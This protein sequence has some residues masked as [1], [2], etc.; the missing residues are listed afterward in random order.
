MVGGAA[1][2]VEV[3]R[4]AGI[5][6]VIVAGRYIALMNKKS[7]I[8]CWVTGDFNF[9]FKL[10]EKRCE[11][12]EGVGKLTLK[13]DKQADLGRMTFDVQ[14]QINAIN[15]FPDEIETPIVQE[16]NRNDE[17]VSIAISAPLP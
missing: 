2:D 10:I 11:A 15:D 17:V 4:R 3:A 5:D 6:V 14:T 8:A 12:L 7:P 16:L 1:D 13:L 9:T